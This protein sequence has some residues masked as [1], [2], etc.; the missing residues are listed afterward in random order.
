VVSKENS[1][2]MNPSANQVAELKKI[3]INRILETTPIISREALEQLSLAGVLNVL[4]LISGQCGSLGDYYTT[5][6]ALKS[7]VGSEEFWRW[8]SVEASAEASAVVN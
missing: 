7:V 5:V 3:T 6:R 4:F 1:Q 8:P 2:T